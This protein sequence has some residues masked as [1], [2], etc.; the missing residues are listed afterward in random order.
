MAYTGGCSKDNKHTITFYCH[1][2]TQE[3]AAKTTNTPLHSTVTGL[4]RRPQQRQQTH[5]YIPLSLA[6]T[7]GC[8]K[9]NKH[10]ITFHCHWLTQEAVAKTTNTLL[11]S[12]V[13]G[14]HRRLQ[15]RQQ[16]H[17]YIPLSLAYTGGCSKDNKHTI[18]FYCHWLTQEAAAK[19]TN[20]PLHSTVTGLHR[21]PQQRQQ[22][23]YYIPLSLAYTGGCSKDN[24]HT[25]TFH[26]HWLTQEAAA[27]TTNTLLHST[28]TGLHRRLQQR[29]Q[30]HHYIPLSL[31]YTG[32]CSKD[33]K[34][35]ITFHCHWLTQE[36]AAKTT[37]TLLHSTVTGLHRRLQQRQQTHHYI[38]LSLAYTGGCSKD[39]KH[40]ITFHCHWLTQE[41]AAKTTNTPLHSTVTG[42]HRR[43]QQRQQ[44]HYYIPLSLAYTGGCSKDNKHTITFH[45]HW[46]TRE[47][48]AK[49]TNTPLHSTVTDLHR[50]LQQRQQ[51]HHYI[52]LSLAY[53]GG[54]SKDNK[55]T[56]TFH[57]H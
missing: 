14:L 8:S 51:T 34:H 32:G 19:T 25:I 56:I 5:H 50:R 2:L 27:K 28:V 47:A 7:G 41:A 39:N 6:Y 24:K 31:A 3:A 53:T 37:N 49:T 23:H 15:Q 12:T 9:D 33:N 21:R 4:H 38:P 55:H 1:W 26:C 43:L 35:T 54:C 22:T 18:T 16:T 17:H 20:T 42:L 29:Q 10:T 30:T 11:H 52:P 13:T 57:C 48:A 45:C 36:A 44:T 40:T 46:L